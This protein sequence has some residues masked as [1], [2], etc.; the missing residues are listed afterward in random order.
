MLK[1]KLITNC[2]VFAIIFLTSCNNQTD[3]NSKKSQY[4]DIKNSK[5]KLDEAKETAKTIFEFVEQ[6]ETNKITKEQ[7]DLKAEP[8]QIHLD[9]LRLVL[10][11]EEIKELDSFRTQLVNDMVDRKIIR[12]RK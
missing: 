8:L 1:I 7:L 10:T 2:T 9:S 5:S 4:Q 3:T 6:V 11:S 12:D